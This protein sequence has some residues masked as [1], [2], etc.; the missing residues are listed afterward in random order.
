MNGVDLA[1]DIFDLHRR[2]AT[3]KNGDYKSN[4]AYMADSTKFAAQA[5][6]WFSSKHGHK[7]DEGAKSTVWQVPFVEILY[8]AE[9]EKVNDFTRHAWIQRWLLNSNRGTS[10]N[11]KPFRRNRRG[12]WAL[13]C[14]SSWKRLVSTIQQ[15]VSEAGSGNFIKKRCKQKEILL[16]TSH[17]NDGATCITLKL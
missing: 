3:I 5:L 2:E 13:I 7:H 10:G 17:R 14:S 15:Q 8:T 1:M 4:Q 12:R 9:K 16:R 11:I 6:P